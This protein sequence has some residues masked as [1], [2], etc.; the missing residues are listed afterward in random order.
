VKNTLLKKETKVGRNNDMTVKVLLL[1]AYP[2]GSLGII[3]M[4]LCHRSYTVMQYHA[5]FPNDC[6]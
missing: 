5:M 2:G 4:I 6:Q 3:A 1:A